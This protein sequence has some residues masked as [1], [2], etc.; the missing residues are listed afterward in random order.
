MFKNYFEVIYTRSLNHMIMQNYEPQIKKVCI[1]WNESTYLNWVSGVE[2]C[3]QHQFLPPATI[4]SSSDTQTTALQLLNFIVY[5]PAMPL[6]PLFP[7]PRATFT[8]QPTLFL[9]SYSDTVHRSPPW[10]VLSAPFDWDRGSSVSSPVDTTLI[11]VLLECNYE[12]VMSG[13]LSFIHEISESLSL[14]LTHSKYSINIFLIK[15]GIVIL[16]L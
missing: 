8:L 2:R 6:Y 11:T 14:F 9:P 4:L 7:L 10:K 13:I 16:V 1:S 5:L 12:T 3:V 15:K